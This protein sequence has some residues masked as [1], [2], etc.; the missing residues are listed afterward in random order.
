M[1]FTGF[2]GSE[3]NEELNV[4]LFESEFHLKQNCLDIL[5]LLKTSGS[6]LEKQQIKIILICGTVK[7][8]NFE[9]VLKI[10]KI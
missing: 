2:Y 7:I 1:I 4:S 8:L 5:L 10:K 9:Q 6:F 3:G